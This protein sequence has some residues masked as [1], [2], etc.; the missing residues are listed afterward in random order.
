MIPLG[1]MQK[2]RGDSH[3]DN[4]SPSTSIVLIEHSELSADTW[5]QNLM[6]DLKGTNTSR[7]SPVVTKRQH[8]KGTSQRSADRP[9]LP[10]SRILRSAKRVRKDLDEQEVR[11]V[12]IVSSGT[13][14]DQ[15]RTA[16]ESEH[17]NQ[18]SASND[19]RPPVKEDPASR[20][21]WSRHGTEFTVLNSL[22]SNRIV[23]LY[24]LLH[25]I[26]NVNK[27]QSIYCSPP[28]PFC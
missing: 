2:G 27:S 14:E 12:I 17:P 22:N 15:I 26:K 10:D 5:E 23:L 3:R 11:D 20:Q 21:R 16:K 9:S 7:R 13:T 8:S 4:R 19:F 28:A 18:A 24:I 6:D 25:P 1:T